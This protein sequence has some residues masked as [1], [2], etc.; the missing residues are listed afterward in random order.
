MRVGT[1]SVTGGALRFGLEHEFRVREG[2]RTRDFRTMVHG[3][4]LGQ[5]DLDPADPNAYRLP[6]GAAVTC[7]GAEAEVAL[8]PTTVAPGFALD[9]AARAEKEACALGDRLSDGVSLTG[10]STHLSVSVPDGLTQAVC[11]LYTTSFAPALML[12]VDGPQS[13]GL[14]IRPRPG[15]V[16]LGGEFVAGPNLVAATLFAVASVVA[17]RDAV[18][19]GGRLHRALPELVVRVAPAVERFGWYVDRTAFGGDLYAD[20]RAA[21]LTTLQGDRLSAQEHLTRC[22]ATVAGRL[23]NVAYPEE[24]E[25]VDAVVRGARSLP[26]EGASDEAGTMAAVDVA[27]SPYGAASS[28]WSGDGFDLAPVMV[29]WDLVVFLAVESRKR[30]RAFIAV[31]GLELGTFFDDLL[32][33]RMEDPIA[34]WF[35]RRGQRRRLVD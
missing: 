9:V 7:D 32:L 13:P 28:P 4:G 34:R 16:E 12:L 29:T 33:G 21:T 11:R 17:C 15:R 27:P 18:S 19:A 20:G 3:L 30:R 23:D 1:P 14:L 35:D 22:W 8:P 5:C 24:R 2:D 31:P 6:S 26:S 25:L 10:C